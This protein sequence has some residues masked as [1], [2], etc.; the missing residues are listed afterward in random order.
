[1]VAAPQ[2]G[3]GAA[4]DNDFVSFTAEDPA[5]V[6]LNRAAGRDLAHELDASEAELVFGRR[7]VG[8]LIGHPAHRRHPDLA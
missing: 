2:R 7:A 5:A 8:Q 4:L 3:L 6:D 1:L